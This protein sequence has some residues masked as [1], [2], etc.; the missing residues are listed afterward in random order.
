VQLRGVV[1]T[2][3]ILEYS[4]DNDQAPVFGIVGSTT[5]R[6]SEKGKLSE[7]ILLLPKTQHALNNTID[8]V[9]IFL[10]HCLPVEDMLFVTLQPSMF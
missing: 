8:L 3:I 2:Y 7:D 1:A 10:E 9:P 4:P 6:R 5:V